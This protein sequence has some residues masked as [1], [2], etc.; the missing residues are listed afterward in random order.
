MPSVEIYKHWTFNF[1]NFVN[2]S[3]RN[4]P[5]WIPVGSQQ[6]VLNEGILKNFVDQTQ[7]KIKFKKY[8]FAKI[9][10]NFASICQ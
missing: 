1:I 8:Y 10:Q 3:F 5:G 4:W 9:F 7:P 2:V 6:V